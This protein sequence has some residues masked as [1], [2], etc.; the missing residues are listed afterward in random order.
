MTL[1]LGNTG[2]P[3]GAARCFFAVPMSAGARYTTYV[4]VPR[5]SAK[6]GRLLVKR[7]GE[8]WKPR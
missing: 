6:E 4:N 2:A 8:Q 5:A 3:D 1:I 7:K